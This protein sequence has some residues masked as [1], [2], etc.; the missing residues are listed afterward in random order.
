MKYIFIINESAGKG[1]YKKILPNIERVCNDRKIQFE[2]RY[3][4]KEKKRM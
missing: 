2:I 3:I 1:K 4:S